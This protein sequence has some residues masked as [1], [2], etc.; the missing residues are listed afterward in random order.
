MLL[1][2]YIGLVILIGAAEVFA[3]ANCRS[4]PVAPHLHPKFNDERRITPAL[5]TPG[6]PMTKTLCAT[7][8]SGSN[9]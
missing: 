7:R 3:D 2:V 1:L 4:S 8:G 5:E 6:R 9:R